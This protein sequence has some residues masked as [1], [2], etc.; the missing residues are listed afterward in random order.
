MKL[1]SLITNLALETDSLSMDWMYL[2]YRQM[3]GVLVDKEQIE[4]INKHE[5]D[6]LRFEMNQAKLS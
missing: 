6:S 3:L 2:N 4:Q 1:S 5:S